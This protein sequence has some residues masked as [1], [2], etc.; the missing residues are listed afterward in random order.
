MMK[1]TKVH[2]L[3]V[4]A[5]CATVALGGAGA[6][7]AD[8]AD[9]QFLAAVHAQGINGDPATLIGF[10]HQMCDVV[11]TPAAIGPMTGLMGSQGLSP[12]QAFTVVMAATRTYCPDKT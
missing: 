9:D 1:V 7:R 3:S 6:A 2:L 5:V 12:Q 10:A 4:A 8:T 11:G